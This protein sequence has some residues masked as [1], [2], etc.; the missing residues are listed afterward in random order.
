MFPFTKFDPKS[1]KLLKLIYGKNDK[2][3]PWQF[4]KITY[5]GK[6]PEDRIK[7]VSGMGHEV[8]SKTIKEMKPYFN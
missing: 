2:V 7:F 4:T 3:R 1:K 6:I 8:N 5:E